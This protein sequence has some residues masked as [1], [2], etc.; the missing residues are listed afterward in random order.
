[1]M[2]NQKV[3]RDF[4]RNA[5]VADLCAP[6]VS[7]SCRK[8]NGGRAARSFVV[9]VAVGKG[10]ERGSSARSVRHL[11]L[12]TNGCKLPTGNSR[13]RVA[14]D[15]WRASHYHPFMGLIRI[16]ASDREWER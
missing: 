7:T 5:R 10:E 13:R 14:G 2:Q 3:S 11:L 6:E 1:M 16:P 15:R 9:A 12:S 4:V 8:N